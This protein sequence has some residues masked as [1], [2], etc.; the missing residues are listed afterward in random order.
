M[1]EAHLGN[2][3]PLRLLCLGAHSDD[4]VIGAA[5]A[6]MTLLEQHPGSAVTWVVFSGDEH[7]VDEARGAAAELLAVATSAAVHTLDFRENHF[8]YQGSA[9]KNAF[10][11]LKE[12]EPDLIFSHARHDRHQ[13]HRT[14]AELTWNAFRNHLVLEYEIPKYEGDLKQPNLYVPLGDEVLEC[15]LEL[16]SRHFGSRHDKPW[17]DADTFR[18]LMRLRGI[19]C[20]AP[21]GYAEGFH[22]SKFVLG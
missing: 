18:G 17:F 19:E 9:L 16:L 3:G 11:T 2:G 7:Q 10:E 22:A 21:S 4:L 12:T 5:G 1:L 6:V 13:D 20:R 15:K 14:L 8:P